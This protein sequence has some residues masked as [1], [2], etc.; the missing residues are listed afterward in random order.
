MLHCVCLSVCRFAIMAVC[1]SALCLCLSVY[2]SVCVYV[3]LSVC[4]YV[5][6]CLSVC[7]FAIMAVCW[8]ALPEERPKFSHLHVCLQDFYT[9]LSK[10]VWRH[11]AAPWSLTAVSTQHNDHTQQWPHRLWWLPVM[12]TTHIAIYCVCLL[13]VTDVITLYNNSFI[14]VITIT[15]VSYQYISSVIICHYHFNQWSATQ[16]LKRRAT[17]LCICVSLSVCVNQSVC[18]SVSVTLSL[19][20]S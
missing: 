8:S 18:R 13:H 7:R 20:V 12:L 1:W 15:I 9:T 3:Y 19:C 2:L 14:I 17:S 11:T 6:I 16:Q 10:F 4:V 5:Y